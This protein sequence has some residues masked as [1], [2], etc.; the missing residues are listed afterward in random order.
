VVPLFYG[1]EE[2]VPQ[3]RAGGL[4]RCVSASHNDFQGDYALVAIVGKGGAAP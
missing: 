2:L 1:I 3:S 4:F